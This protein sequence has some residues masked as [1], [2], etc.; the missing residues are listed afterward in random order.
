[1]QYHVAYDVLREWYDLRLSLLLLVPFLFG[2]FITVVIWR[3]ALHD[4]REPDRSKRRL[5]TNP[6]LGFVLP[7]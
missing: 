4:L 1:M 3:A 7:R 6:F 2:V 5:G